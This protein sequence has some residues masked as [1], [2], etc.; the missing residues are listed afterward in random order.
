MLETNGWESMWVKPGKVWGKRWDN[1]F[2]TF[3]QSVFLNSW[4]EKFDLVP[5]GSIIYDDSYGILTPGN[6]Y[7]PDY[8]I[9]YIRVKD[10][11]PHME[12]DFSE[13]LKVPEKY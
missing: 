4:S 11:R 5:L 12:I 9:T 8:P 6:V 13:V 10:M 1:G 2:H 3:Q 7:S